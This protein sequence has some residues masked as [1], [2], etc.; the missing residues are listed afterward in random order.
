M[1]TQHEIYRAWQRLRMNAQVRVMLESPM[2]YE[3]CDA[4]ERMLY[5]AARIERITQQDDAVSWRIWR[6]HEVHPKTIPVWR[7]I[8]DVIRNISIMPVLKNF[9]P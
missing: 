3:K 2:A 8:A 7:Q 1:K 5:M 9:I 4:V 6:P